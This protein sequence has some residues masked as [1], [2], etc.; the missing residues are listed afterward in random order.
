MDGCNTSRVQALTMIVQVFPRLQTLRLGLLQREF[1]ARLF[2][3]C[4][5]VNSLE[6]EGWDDVKDIRTLRHCPNLVSL[7]LQ[8]SAV[9]D[10]SVLRY[11]LGY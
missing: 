2:K 6:L 7:D 5:K 8:N 11:G 1:R 4:A 3:V 9:A 10:I